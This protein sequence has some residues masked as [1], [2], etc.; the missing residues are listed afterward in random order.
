MYTNVIVIGIGIATVVRMILGM[1]WYSPSVFGAT[2]MKLIGKSKKDIKPK[3]AQVAILG[4]I[5]TSIIISAMLSCL[6]TRLGIESIGS[7]VLLGISVWFG[8]VATNG[9]GGVL[10]EK[11]SVQ[12]FVLTTGYE[13]VAYGLTGGVLAYFV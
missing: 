7:G 9:F 4:G 6:I 13:L 5:L 11:R 3:D 10:W 1:I 2:W 8:F 12:W